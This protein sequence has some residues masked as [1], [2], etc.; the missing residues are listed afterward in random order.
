MFH[1]KQ[2]IPSLDYLRVTSQGNSGAGVILDLFE[3][4][5]SARGDDRPLYACKTFRALGYEGQQADHVAWGRRGDGG[6]LQMAGH[7]AQEFGP[8]VMASVGRVTRVDLQTT[9]EFFEQN[10]DIP[11]SVVEQLSLFSGDREKQVYYARI[12]N[13]LMGQTVYVNRRTSDQ[14]G[15]IYDK[16]VQADTQPPGFVWRYEVELKGKPAREASISLK[17][18]DFDPHWIEAFVYQWFSKRGVI[19]RWETGKVSIII[20]RETVVS[21]DLKTISWLHRCVSPVIRRLAEQGKLDL[22]SEAIGFDISPET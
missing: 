13:S 14:F 21:D 2:L 6:M 15:R 8:L 9:V 1:V 19:P 12:T 10:L 7:V 22:A 16:G 17:K 11:A 3:R 4:I 20:E 18:A 5:R